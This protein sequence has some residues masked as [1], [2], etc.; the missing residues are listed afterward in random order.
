M[1][2]WFQNRRT[3]W[4]KQED[5]VNECHS[6]QFSKLQTSVASESDDTIDNSESLCEHDKRRNEDQVIDVSPRS[7][8]SVTVKGDC[9]SME[10]VRTRES[11]CGNL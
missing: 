9:L 8:I 3:K 6:K 11:D 1:K 7:D 5:L 2:I 10:D 4:K